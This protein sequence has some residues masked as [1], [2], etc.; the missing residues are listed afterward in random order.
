MP[1]FTDIQSRLQKVLPCPVCLQSVPRRH[2]VVLNGCKHALCRSC[3]IQYLES[4]AGDSRLPQCVMPQCQRALDMEQCQLVLH[5]HK[6]VFEKLSD[7]AVM[8][9]LPADIRFICPY[10]T[11]SAISLLDSGRDYKSQQQNCPHCR[12]P[13]CVHCKCIWHDGVTCDRYEGAPDDMAVLSLA[14][15]EGLARCPGCRIVTQKTQ[16]CD[17]MKC[18]Q[19][20]TDYAYSVAR[21]F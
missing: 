6:L 17:H 21:V 8:E 18:T 14:R 2:S 11:C 9:S 3:L 19:C 20:R 13:V 10:P 1:R 4:E 5:Q 7:L 12:Q 15:Q 16:G